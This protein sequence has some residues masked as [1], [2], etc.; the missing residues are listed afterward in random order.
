MSDG[1]TPYYHETWFEPAFAAASLLVLFLLFHGLMP[2]VEI[3]T[4]VIETVAMAKLFSEGRFMDAFSRFNMPPVYPLLLALV[5]KIRH[6]TELPRLIE[7][8][9]TLNLVLGMISAGLVHYFVR[10][11]IAK[12]YVFI[13][14][15]LYVLAPS[16]LGMAWS[17]S[18]QMTYMVMSMAT[19]IAID[20]SLSKES[21]LGGQLSRGEVI[22]CG[23]FL[24]LSILS[25]QV[26][27]LM[28]LA[29]MVV[30]LKRFGLKKSLQV[31]A[32]I[33][34]CISPFIG[35]D[36]FYV[37]RSP[38]E[39]TAS[40]ASIMRSFHDR[41]F[42]NTVGVYAD[43]ITLNIARNAIGDLNLS[44]LDRLAQT[45]R[46]TEPDHMSLMEK[47]WLRWLIGFVA[48]VGAIYG[49]SQY[50]GIGSIYMCLYV[51][52]AMAL[53]P[54]AG[55]TLAPVLP[56][57]LFYLYCGLL[58]TGQW[59]HRLDMPLLTRVA[60]PVLTVWILLCTLTSHISH[61]N[62]H[63]VHQQPLVSTHAPKVMYMS[64]PQQ[65]ESRLEE[66]QVTSAQRRA[67]DWLKSHASQKARVGAAR[68][69]AASLLADD[70]NVTPAVKAA[71]QQALK[72]ELGQYDYLVE[73]GAAQITP[74]KAAATK[75]LKMVYED[76]PGRIRIWQ[77]RPSM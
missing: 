76:V 10:R 11:Q 66:A 55:L 69:E 54:S 22:L 40:T 33:M 53:L 12:P 46:A 45:P 25:W 57:L 59:M 60:A 58:R 3:N 30:M 47:P 7:S 35:R 63:P 23:A 70:K 2:S 38:Q 31:T 51:I 67:T 41:G 17:L 64:T 6:T 62:G 14:T 29:F 73:E 34:L 48:T 74:S 36:L 65:P 4:N 21:V 68:P 19:L 5:I 32:G 37:V 50:T 8:F 77:V 9:R 15:A 56:L 1:T 44:S 52:T 27:Y 26:G 71:R 18:P 75:G 13:I 28:L 16:T 42:F 43:N 49:L 20:I 24:A 61:V 72:S 39:Y